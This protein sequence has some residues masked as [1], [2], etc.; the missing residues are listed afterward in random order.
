VPR[1]TGTA[2]ELGIGGVRNLWFYDPTRVTSVTGVDPSEAL[3]IKTRA[4][5]HGA[6]L[7]VEIL[8]GEAENLPFADLS[9]DTIVCTFTLCSVRSPEAALLEARRVPKPGGVFLFCEH[10]LAPDLSIERWQRRIEPLWKRLAEGCHLTRP[11]TATIAS[12]GFKIPDVQSMYLPRT[13]RV[14][15]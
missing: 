5:P 6:G 7:A 3:L 10:G 4:A 9:F 1:A 8:G 15:G 11:V 14:V 13:P 2:L 12:T